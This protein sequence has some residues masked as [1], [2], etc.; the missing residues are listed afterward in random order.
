M[1]V[2]AQKIGTSLLLVSKSH[3]CKEMG[4]AGIQCCRGSRDSDQLHDGWSGVR[5]PVE[6][7]DIFL[8][9]NVK[10]GS[11]SMVTGFLSIQR[12]G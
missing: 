12:R 7:K 11:Y 9:S 6:A 2:H 4:M 8:L 1:E 3:T 10:T 5:F